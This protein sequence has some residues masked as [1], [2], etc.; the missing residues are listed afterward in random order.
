[1]HHQCSQDA[2]LEHLMI[3]RTLVLAQSSASGATKKTGESAKSSVRSICWRVYDQDSDCG[4]CFGESLIFSSHPQRSSWSKLCGSSGERL[5][6]CQHHCWSRVPRSKM[7]GFLETTRNSTRSTSQK[8][9][10][11]FL[12]G[13]STCWHRATSR[14]MFYCKNETLQ[15]TLLSIGEN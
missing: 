10:N 13:G 4:R 5:E 6:N 9:S 2:D 12:G 3:D 7:E 1:M 11:I 15:K 8:K 14:G